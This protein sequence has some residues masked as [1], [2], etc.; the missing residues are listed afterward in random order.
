MIINKCYCVPW[1]PLYK[2]ILEDVPEIV[3]RTKLAC[4]MHVVVQRDVKE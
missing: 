2:T 1:P 3:L 4:L